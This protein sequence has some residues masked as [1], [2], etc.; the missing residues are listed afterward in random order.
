MDTGRSGK[1]SEKRSDDELALLDIS[2]DP[3]AAGTPECR[4]APNLVRGTQVLGKAVETED[5]G[6]KDL[7]LGLVNREGIHFASLDRGEQILASR[8]N[9]RQVLHPIRGMSLPGDPEL[10]RGN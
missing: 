6:A 3:V 8:V 1:A 7:E 5:M 4:S 2:L 10:L 9:G